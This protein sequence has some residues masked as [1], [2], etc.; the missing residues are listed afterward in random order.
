MSDNDVNAYLIACLLII[1]GVPLVV[2]AS[3]DADD[4]MYH[5]IVCPPNINKIT[6]YNLEEI[7]QCHLETKFK[8]RI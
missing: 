7:T 3:T 8:I 6:L 2:D 1:F 4:N 5:E